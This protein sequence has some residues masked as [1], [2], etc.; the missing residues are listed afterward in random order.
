MC[1][2]LHSAMGQSM[3]VQLQQPTKKSSQV[4]PLSLPHLYWHFL[5]Y[6]NHLDTKSLEV[7]AKGKNGS[8]MR[9]YLQ[10]KL[11]FSDADFAAIRASSI[12]LTAEVK[13]LDAKALAVQKAGASSS[14]LDQLK[15]LTLK[16]EADINAEMS[17][18]KQ[19]LPPDKLT[20]FETFMTQ[21]FSPANAAPRPPSMAGKPVSAEV[22]K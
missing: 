4:R 20:A 3:P 5:V 15:A 17:Y 16:R 21:F 2:L 13:D 7:D 1:A 11:G 19:T 22:Q 10:G 18:L 8:L 9:N 6:V 14:N 12:R